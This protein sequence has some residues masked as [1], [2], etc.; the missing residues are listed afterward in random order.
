MDVTEFLGLNVVM[1][2]ILVIVVVVYL[3][4][5]IRKRRRGKFLHDDH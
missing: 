5:L 4:V 2:G 3:V 1:V